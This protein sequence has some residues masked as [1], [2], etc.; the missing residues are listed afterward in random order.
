[1]ASLFA[2][3]F[4]AVA[5]GHALVGG[6]RP[7]KFW[8]ASV[9]CSCIPDADVIGFAFG[10]RYADALGHRG[11]SHSIVFAALLSAAV[12]FTS[13]RESLEN[14]RL[15]WLL[16]VHFFVVT[17]SHGVLDAM[18]DGGLGVAF[19]APFD[20]TRYFLPWRPIAVSPIGAAAFFSRWGLEV[21]LNELG[22]IWAPAGVAM[23]AAVLV[24]RSRRNDV[25]R[26]AGKR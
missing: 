13:F 22:V 17:A 24:R 20:N 3:G 2:H 12:V 23:V 4:V 18:T 25:E 1:M 10:I 19:F 16:L 26:D 8:L 9:L 15:T 6:P 21:I 7:R 11:F 14:R 5:A